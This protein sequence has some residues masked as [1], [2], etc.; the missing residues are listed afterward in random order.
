[1]PGGV[2]APTFIVKVD[3]AEPPEGGVTEVGLKTAVVPVGRPEMDR[4]TAELKP[5]KDVT[6]MV[7]VPDP[8]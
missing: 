7:E 1:V 3:V 2:E 5:L 8:P 4:L 6:V